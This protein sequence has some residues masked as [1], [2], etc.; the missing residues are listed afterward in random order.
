MPIW[1]LVLI[2]SHVELVPFTETPDLENIAVFADIPL[3]GTENRVFWP[4]SLSCTEI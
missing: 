2:L 1:H 4:I 3:T